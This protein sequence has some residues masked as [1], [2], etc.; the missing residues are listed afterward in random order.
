MNELS[1]LSVGNSIYLETRYIETL[2]KFIEFSR[3]HIHSKWKLVKNP[4]DCNIALYFDLAVSDS[5]NIVNKSDVTKVLVRQEPE[6]VIPENYEANLIKKFDHVIDI[7]KSK[8]DMFLNI[9]WPQDLS[10]PY[11]TGNK[12]KNKFVMI[13][14]NLL[15][16]TRN[17]NY[18]LRR[19]IVAK[20]FEVDLFGFNWNNN[21]FEKFLT[22]VKEFKK[23]LPRIYNIEL[24]GL[25]YYFKTFDNY[26]GSVVNK[27]EVMSAYKYSIVI[28]NS[29]NYVSEKL[30]D[31]L[32]TGCMPIYVGPD[33]SL[34]DLPK[35]LYL[36]AQPN[37]KDIK[38]KM[39]Q[40]QELNY[41]EWVENVKFWLE[42]AN[43]KEIWSQEF[44]FQKIL[45]AIKKIH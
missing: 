28:E 26:L 33:L 4:I 36:Q 1:N 20:I 13:N 40:A 2:E 30:F 17:Q 34:Y 5:M 22:L 31:S 39:I 41:E 9:N 8:E 15:S 23:Y 29:S 14:S 42:Q 16:L 25:R 21:F 38:L 18:S 10:H 27:R 37:F 11:I 3:N 24:S 6:L 35:N 32:V 44:F 19:E 7:G 12:R 45:T 43:T